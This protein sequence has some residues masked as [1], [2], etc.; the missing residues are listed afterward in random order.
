MPNCTQC[1]NT[2][3]VT[4]KDRATL[5]K[6]TP[7]FNGKEFRIPDPTLCFECRLQ[8]KLTF[9]NSK[10]LYKR[11][12]AKTGKQ[13]VSMYSPDKNI[14]VYEKDAWFG[15]D[16][17]PFDYGRDYDF[18]RP[19]FEQW[20]ELRSS[21]PLPSLSLMTYNQ[22]TDYAND[23][24]KMKNCYLV[25]DGEQAEDCFYGQTFIYVKNCMDFLFVDKCEVCYESI[26]CYTCYNTK[27]SRFCHNCSD[28]YFLCD[29]NGCK[30]C[31]GCV[32]LHQKEYCIFNEQKTREEYE[33][34]IASFESTKH[35]AVAHYRKMAE[36]Y[37]LKHPIKES[38]CVQNI[39]CSGD[40]LNRS[41]DTAVTF[42]SNEMQDCAYCTNCL[43]GGKDSMDVHTWG[44]SMELCYEG[45][46]TGHK[47]RNMM[48]NMYVYEGCTNVYYSMYCTRSCNNLFGCIG[49]RHQNYCI[50]NKQY[51]PE[52]YNALAAQIVEQMQLKGEW[53]EFFPTDISMFGYNET[54][55][56][57]FYPMTKE[58]VLAKGLKW[59]D[60]ESPVIA[61][62]VIN[63][64]QL[65]DDSNDIPDDVLNWA[66]NCEVTGRP[67][68]ILKQELEFYRTHR[69]PIPRRHPDQRHVDRYVY[70]NKFKL[71]DR[72][73]AKCQKDIQTPYSPDQPE[74]VYCDDCYLAVVY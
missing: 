55:A 29:C 41:K 44:D 40:N 36:D 73:C 48:C 31:F 14:T 64:T 9:Y 60:Y 49:L 19:F 50:F 32:N 11:E 62:K 45:L 56:Q 58:E 30:H 25:F 33:A 22:N 39:N 63:A 69:L 37:F 57:V 17:N 70:K 20:E 34:F 28:S 67:Y 4:E 5:D 3:E 8:R 68:K 71:W 65:P 10:N 46:V 66:I 53:G 6:M 47:I 7:V 1:Q 16:W 27:Y 24:Y 21:V 72:R 15:D 13:I 12:C 35:S 42:D 54:M 38:R 51:T 52:E 59:S 74:I 61:D 23:A 2:F 18:N 26:H 43:M